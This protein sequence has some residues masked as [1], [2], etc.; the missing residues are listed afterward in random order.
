MAAD[1]YPKIPGYSIMSLLGRGGMAQVYLAREEHLRRLVALKVIADRYDANDDFRRRFE[2]EARTAAGLTHPNI[3]PVYAYGFTEGGSPYLSM[4]FLDGGSLRERLRKHGPLRVDEAL[5]IA[6]Q[7]ASALG[8]AHTRNVVHRDL[9]PD[10]VMFQGEN[11]LLTDFGIAKVLDATTG[12]TGTGVNPGTVS[13]F[14]PEQAEGKAVDQRSDIYTLGVVLYEM[15]TGRLPIQAETYAAFVFRILSRPPEP[16]PPQ[17]AGLQPFM[18]VL[19]GKD[20]AD[21]LNSCAEVIAIIDAMV[22]NW[23]RHG[24]VERLTDGVEMRPSGRRAAER[25]LDEDAGPG[26]AADRTA[27]PDAPTAQMPPAR[28]AGPGTDPTLALRTL[29]TPPPIIPATD[30]GRTCALTLDVS[31]AT[32]LVTVEYRDA[33]GEER[34]EL[35]RGRALRL[36]VGEVRLSANAPGHREVTRRLRLAAG[37]R[38]EVIELEALPAAVPELAPVVTSAPAQPEPTPAQA[39]APK[40][41]TAAQPASA[42]AGRSQP[43]GAAAQG[44][45]RRA[46]MGGGAVL[47]LAVA[48]GVWTL[49]GDNPSVGQAAVTEQPSSAEPAVAPAGDATPVEQPQVDPRREALLASVAGRWSL[50]GGSDCARF[51]IAGNVLVQ[52]WPGIADARERVTEVDV[53]NGVV[54]TVVELPVEEAGKVYHYTPRSG[55]RLVF[56]DEGAGSNDTLRACGGG[57]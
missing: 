25:D 7:I 22:A 13:Y 30:P 32:A 50:P 5:P 21:R 36:P 56:E 46:L 12:L 57:G 34:A 45:D 10:N 4:A 17:L 35:W 33:G 41:M 47:V 42:A 53:A 54:T 20:P 37:A 16:L 27:D 23:M 29:Q 24:S 31:P 48:I 19:L 3:V 18:D 49:G 9:K 26:V 40:P 51:T 43:P 1:A 2:R 52:R 11:T 15:L 55:G 6:R 39:A 14:S 28:I 44:M 8:A 38:E